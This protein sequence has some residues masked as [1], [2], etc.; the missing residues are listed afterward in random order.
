MQKARRHPPHHEWQCRL[1]PLVGTRFQVLLTRRLGVLFTFPS[2]YL[3]TI[4]HRGVFSLA[5]WCRPI[6]TGFLRPRPTQDTTTNNNACAYRAFT[7]C[8]RSFQGRSTSHYRQISWSY[9]PD[10]HWP[11]VW[12]SPRSLAT[13]WGITVV[14]FSCPYLDVSVRGVRPRPKPGLGVVPFGNPRI[15][16]SLQLPAAY[17]SFAR[18]SSPLGAKASTM[19]PLVLL[20]F[21]LHMRVCSTLWPTRR[22]A[23]YPYC[24]F[25]P[26]CQRTQ[27]PDHRNP[28]R[29]TGPQ[30][31][32]LKKNHP[33]LL[34]ELAG[35]E[36]ATSCLQG[37]R[38]SQL[39]YSPFG[40]GLGRS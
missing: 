9:N 7:F 35:I 21:G 8:G 36:P 6:Q 33:L 15:T 10:G 19:C 5:G 4:G 11:P 23:R 13:T 18:P 25:Y 26:I 38:S 17:R 28:V 29:T 40:G 3:F 22:P 34:V 1:R 37:R 39:S 2:R 31:G 14:F 27:G 16:A 30:A 12:A 20:F 24:F 32:H